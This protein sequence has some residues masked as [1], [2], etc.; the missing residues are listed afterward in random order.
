MGLRLLPQMRI[1]MGW[2][3]HHQWGSGKSR[4]TKMRRLAPFPLCDKVALD[5]R[6]PWPTPPAMVAHELEQWRDA[7]AVER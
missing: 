4:S 2:F 7:R 5:A 3:A 1:Q 6:L